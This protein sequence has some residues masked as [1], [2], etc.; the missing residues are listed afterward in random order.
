MRSTFLF[1]ATLFAS[2]A[3]VFAH[4]PGL[5]SAR[6]VVDGKVIDAVVTFNQRDLESLGAKPDELTGEL[7]RFRAAETT[8]PLKSHEAK[9]DSAQNIEF[10]L[11]FANVAAGR[12]RIDS[13]VIN[14]L[15]FGHRQMLSVRSSNG[16]NL[17]ERLL[18][19]RE[20][21][22]SVDVTGPPLS[23]SIAPGGFAQFFVLGLQHILTGYDHLLFLAGILIVCASFGG[24][25]RLIT[26]FTVAHSITLALATFNLIAIPSRIVEPMIAASIVY[27]GIE[28]LWKGG[29]LH[30]R[31]V[32][33]FTFGLVHGLGF[34]S[35]LREMGIGIGSGGVVLPLFSFNFGVEAGQLLV[36]ALVL[37][38]ML[39]CKNAERF[40][41]MAVPVTSCLIASAGAYWFFQRIAT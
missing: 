33:T 20:N 14:R 23:P 13:G 18:S 25:A 15:P 1:A 30:W 8:L 37:P 12:L 3:F 9:I 27:V 6:I 11:R 28:N 5:S 29:N 34:A 40:P 19:A 2:A 41:R 24:A 38:L 10:H 7:L 16:E 31:E 4:D 21:E 17:G 26:C 22:L 35:V 36:A 32:L 39:K